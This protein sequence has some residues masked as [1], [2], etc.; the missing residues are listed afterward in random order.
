LFLCEQEEVK[1]VTIDGFTDVVP[2]SEE[3]LME[4]VAKQPVSVA[5]EAS[6][7]DFQLYEGVSWKCEHHHSTIHK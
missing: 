7:W 6:A 1:T 4:A 5:I 3:A 2:F